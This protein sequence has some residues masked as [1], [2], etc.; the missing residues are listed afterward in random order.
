MSNIDLGGNYFLSQNDSRQTGK[1][2]IWSAAEREKSSL[3]SL[4]VMFAFSS[5]FIPEAGHSPLVCLSQ[6]SLLR[7][8]GHFNLHYNLGFLWWTLAY[9]MAFSLIVLYIGFCCK[10]YHFALYLGLTKNMSVR[11]RRE[12][13]PLHWEKLCY[14]R[15]MAW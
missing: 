12:N 10:R 7:C 3:E 13:H 6:P 9:C 5:T 2:R 1:D 4:L 8:L 14:K 15:W 11:L